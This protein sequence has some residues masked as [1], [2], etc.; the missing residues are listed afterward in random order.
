MAKSIDRASPEL[1]ERIY[2]NEASDKDFN[3]RSNMTAYYEHSTGTFNIGPGLNLDSALVIAA[4]KARDINAADLKDSFDFHNKQLIDPELVP[5]MLEVFNE[6]VNNS[7]KDARTYV[8]MDTWK[9]LKLHEKDT[10]H[11]M[12][13]QMGLGELSGF[14]ETKKKLQFYVNNP[15]PESR[16]AVTDE[17]LNSKWA[18][19][20]S[21]KRALR[22]TGGFNQGGDEPNIRLQTGLLSN[23]DTNL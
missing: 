11:E 3:D 2:Q 15:S 1:K 12:S 19:E 7:R 6:V 18:R 21:P 10:I 22:V 16:S 23:D 9:K 13:Y 8:E 5:I 20:D 17:M 14:T 4:L